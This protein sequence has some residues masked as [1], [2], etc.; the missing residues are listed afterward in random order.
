QRCF[1]VHLEASLDERAARIRK[2]EGG[3][4]EKQKTATKERDARDHARY[5]KLYGIDN[6]EY[7]FADM[8]IQTDNLTQH[9]VAEMIIREVKAGYSRS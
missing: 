5:L 9:E 7:S 3:D 6:D 4:M 1:E 2:R 8:I